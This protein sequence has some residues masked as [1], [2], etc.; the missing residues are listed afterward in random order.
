MGEMNESPQLQGVQE[1]NRLIRWLNAIERVGNKLPQPFF[2]FLY[3]AIAI[4]IISYFAQGTSVEVERA[5]G[6][7][8]QRVTISVVNLLNPNYIRNILTNWVSIYVN[9]PPLGIVMVMMLAIGYAQ[10]S[11][12]AFSIRL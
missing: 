11:T 6:G 9:F 3:F 10:P 5:V 12:A 8:M 1:S 4:M 2:L 7:E